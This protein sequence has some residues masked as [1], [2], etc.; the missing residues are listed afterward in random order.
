MAPPLDLVAFLARS[1]CYLAAKPPAL[2]A[3]LRLHLASY[4]LPRGYEIVAMLPR[5]TEDVPVKLGRSDKDDR[6][7]R[8]PATRV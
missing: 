4:K 7:N 6:Q 3:H 8:R 5:S 1:R 2:E